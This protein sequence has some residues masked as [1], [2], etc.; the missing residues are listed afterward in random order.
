MSADVFL[1]V[2][3]HSETSVTRAR[4]GLNYHTHTNTRDIS[5]WACGNADGR[6]GALGANF[7]LRKTALKV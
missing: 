6:A 3:R 2:D 7:T 4:I 1:D 5:P